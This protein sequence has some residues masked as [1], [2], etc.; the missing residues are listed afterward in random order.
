MHIIYARIK[1]E[2]L[3]TSI[4][5]FLKCNIT[6][7]ND[8]NTVL[9]WSC[10]NFAVLGHICS[11]KNVLNIPI[12]LPSTHNLNGMTNIKAKRKDILECEEGYNIQPHKDKCDINGHC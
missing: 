3:P 7:Y 2:F 12:I 11:H 1:L 6:S 4:L 10:I 9:I 5:R 8:S